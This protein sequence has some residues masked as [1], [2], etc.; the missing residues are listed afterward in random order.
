[1]ENNA[2]TVLKGKGA[3]EVSEIVDTAM[4][5]EIFESVSKKLSP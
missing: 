3:A 5:D 1:M 2:K 4:L